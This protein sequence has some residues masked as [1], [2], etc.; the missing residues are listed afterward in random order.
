MV[1]KHEYALMHAFQIP[2]DED[3]MDIDVEN[4][5]GVN[6]CGSASAGKDGGRSS[7]FIIKRRTDH[8]AGM[9]MP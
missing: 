9:P 8:H 6:S 1:S 4:V 2:V 5:P 7:S 3:A